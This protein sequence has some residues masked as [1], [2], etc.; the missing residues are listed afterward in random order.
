MRLTGRLLTADGDTVGFADDLSDTVA[1]ADARLKRVLAAIPGPRE[2][3][4][5]IT[6][7]EGPDR[8]HLTREGIHSVVWATGFGPSYPWLA[9]PVLD[10]DGHLRHRRGVTAAP[11]LYAVGLRFQ[12]RRDSTFIDGARHDAAYLADLIT[13]KR[14]QRTCA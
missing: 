12:H 4:P 1:A 3:I 2:E 6:I 11:G 14:T 5:A 10:H 7:H 8:L 13:A 9:V